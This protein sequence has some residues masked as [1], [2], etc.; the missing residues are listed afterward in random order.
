MIQNGIY[1]MFRQYVD[2]DKEFGCKWIDKI[3]QRL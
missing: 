2:N 1:I 3:M